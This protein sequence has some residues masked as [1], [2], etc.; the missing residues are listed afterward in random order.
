M[1]TGSDCITPILSAAEQSL[2]NR[3]VPV[4]KPVHSAALLGIGPPFP[5]RIPKQSQ[6]P[7]PI[8]GFPSRQRVLSG[9]TTNPPARRP[10]AH[11]S[12]TDEQRLAF[13]TKADPLSGCM[14][15]QGEATPAGYGRLNYKGRTT[16]AHRWA[17]TIKH[18]PIAR[19]MV[20]CHRC[21]QRRCVNVDHLF[22]GPQSDNMAYMQAKW[23]RRRRLG[24]RNYKVQGGLPPD[25]HPAEIAPIRIVCGEF[26][27]VGDV[28]LR[29]LDRHVQPPTPSPA[30]PAGR[31]PGARSRRC[32][33]RRGRPRRTASPARHGR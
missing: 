32:A 30:P 26:E 16:Y 20:V 23:Q 13:W 27:L 3:R 1:V 28:V 5:M 15:W 31:A 29:P 6:K 18:G 7:L 21:D 24:V 33:A 17:W 4:E 2:S 12:W 8:I 9:M 14:I 10:Y 25:A 22:L 19:G 11:P